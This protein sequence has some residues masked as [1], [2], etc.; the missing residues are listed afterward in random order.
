MVT[1]LLLVLLLS[2]SLRDAWRRRV[3]PSA[4]RSLVVLLKDQESGHLPPLSPP[5]LRASPPS[6]SFLTEIREARGGGRE[7]GMAEIVE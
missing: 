3:D 5:L 4:L 7:R 2:P 1:F 6:S